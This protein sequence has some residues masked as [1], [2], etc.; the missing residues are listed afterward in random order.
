MKC[1]KCNSELEH[2][3]G[4][5]IEVDE[6]PKCGG[7]WLDE[8]A[9]RKAKDHA[10]P[11]T[12]WMDFELWKHQDLFKAAPKGVLC[13]QCNAN[14]VQIEYEHTGVIV[15]Y[16]VKCHGVW[17]DAGE[18]EKIVDALQ[19]ELLTKSVSGYFKAALEEAK[20]LVTGPES[21]ISEW[22][23]LATVVRMLELRILTANPKLQQSL[24]SI[25]RRAPFV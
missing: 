8:G 14:L 1:P 12:N 17:L 24:E 10:D 5:S 7:V 23:D 3:A 19:Q 6:C 16:C 11:D 20:E 21:F 4:S 9:L 18:F 25:Q 15:D 22:R 13:P 2:K